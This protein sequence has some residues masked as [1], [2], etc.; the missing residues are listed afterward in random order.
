MMTPRSL[1]L[2]LALSVPLLG[3]AGSG[4]Q[5]YPDLDREQRAESGLFGDGGVTIFGG[6]DGK[7]AARA[8]EAEAEARQ[9]V[10]RRMRTVNESPATGVGVNGFLWR[11]TLD[12]LSFMPIDSA[13]PFGGTIITDWYSP[14]GVQ[15]E[16]FKVNAFI[17]SPKLRADGIRVSVFR[18]ALSR[19]GQWLDASVSDKTAA[20]LERTILTRARELR[21]G[22]PEG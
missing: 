21:I 9:P 22:Q 19:G 10:E 15:N 5:G 17:L 1:L 2:T 7:G 14:P 13:D 6:G 11:A 12:T 4:D 20:Q 8:A 16:R 18:Q 3:C